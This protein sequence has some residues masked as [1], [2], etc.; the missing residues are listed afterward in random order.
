MSDG[1]SDPAGPGH[2]G[3]TGEGTG[4]GQPAS[5]G[6][7]GGT[8]GPEGPR[9]QADGPAGLLEEMQT[10]RREA[11]ALRHAYWFPLILFGL[12][13]CAAAPFY[14]PP[15]PPPQP[16]TAILVAQ[17]GLPLPLLG[18]FPSFTVQGGLGYYWLAA[19]LGGVLATL[20]AY[21][22]NARRVG[23]QTPSRGYVIT[24]AALTIAALLV[25]LLSQ[26]RSPR[27][28]AWLQALH[29]LAPG[30]L[31]LRGTFPFIIIAAGLWVLARAERSRA[32]AVI[33]ALYSA[34]ALLA[35]LYNVENILFRLGWTPSAADLGLTA[36]PNVLL[37]A[38]VLLTAGAGAFAVQRRHR[39]RS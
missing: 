19:L 31:A 30:D 9:G 25:P 20:L 21:R 37:P 24:V 2:E 34:A 7:R 22:W 33:A 13:T 16:G 12:L 11:R 28:L 4:E 32:L 3:P 36:L 17:P 39:A 35:S 5:E 10:L 1:G 26:V 18:G 6:A 29:V 14:L 8:P 27:W 38:L 15:G 23:L